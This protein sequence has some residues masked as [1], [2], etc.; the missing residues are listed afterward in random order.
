LR[1]AAGGERVDADPAA[2][3]RLV[4]LCD[5][6]PLALAVVAEQAQRADSLG[7]VAKTLGDETACLIQFGC[8]AD[9]DLLATLS[10]SYRSLE[11]MAAAV[12][13]KLGRHPAG[14]FGLETAAALADLP[15]AHAKQVLDQ[16]VEAHMVERWQADRY[17]LNDL[18][19]LY[20]TE[21]ACQRHGTVLSMPGR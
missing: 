4:D 19:R 5:R 13:R 6:L 8:G 9:I 11:P 10:W 16:L 14:D 18:I 15:V 2:A 17:R 20:A 1:V 3:R 12:F 7:E 21:Q